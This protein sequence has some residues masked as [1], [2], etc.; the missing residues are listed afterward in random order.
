MAIMRPLSAWVD[1]KYPVVCLSVHDQ[2]RAGRDLYFGRCDG[3]EGVVKADFA[4]TGHY[5]PFA[6]GQ[7]HY[8]G[9]VRAVE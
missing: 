9:V 7:L 6:F 1:R 5:L 4:V 2:S 8:L 3:A